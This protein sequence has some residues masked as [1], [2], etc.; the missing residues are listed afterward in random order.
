MSPTATA[1]TT[2]DP[3]G[4]TF[5]QRVDAFIGDAMKTY[6][7]VIRKDSGR[8]AE[9]QQKLHIAHMFLYNKYAST[10]PANTDPGKRTIAWDHLSDPTI[11]WGT[12][13]FEDILRTKAD[14]VPIKEGTKWKAGNE[15]D[16]T[17]T[18]KHLKELLTTEK[19]GNNGEAMV[20]SGT[21]PCAEPCGCGAGRSKHLEDSAA[22]LNS[23]DLQALDTKVQ[24]SKAGDIDEYL[25]KFG[26]HRPLVDHPSSPEKWHV[27]SVD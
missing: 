9:W 27:E 20:S 15:P 6:S 17:A 22:D 3:K 4:K 16:K 25:K 26:L 10:T 21:R 14:G 19:I 11:T 5:N 13:K 12:A 8:T 23:S 18:E 7:L 2:F 1:P 24:T